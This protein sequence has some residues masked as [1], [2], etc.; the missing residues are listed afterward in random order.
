[1][2]AFAY[3]ALAP[4]GALSTGV[5]EAA[6]VA[7]LERRLAVR[8]LYPVALEQAADPASAAGGNARGTIAKPGPVGRGSCRIGGTS[9][10]TVDAVR[11]LATLVE[12]GFP[13]DRALATAARV[14]EGAVLADALASVRERVRAGETLATA[15]AAHPS[16]FPPLAV[17]MIRAGERGGHLAA[18]L[19]RLATT[20]ERER[21]LRARLAAAALYPVVLLV[22]G[23]AAVVLL[24]GVVLP[25]LAG[26]LT[27]S[28]AA[29]P[30][31]TRIVLLAGAVVT[32]WWPLLAGL[33]VA[34]GIAVT[35]TLG[36][37][38]GRDALDRFLYRA[39]G[40]GTLRRQRAAVRFGR[41]LAALLA[42]GAPAVTAID[43]A[44]DAVADAGARD[45][46]HA[47]RDAVRAGER[48]STAIARA[49]LFPPLF[50]QMVDVGESG[51]RL[52]EMLERGAAAMEGA[53]ERTLERLLRLSE[54]FLLVL[55]GGTVGFVA[56]SLLR[57]VYGVRVEGL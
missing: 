45:G 51:G 1:M 24:A 34:I 5:E 16:I 32:R 20:L 13:L 49:A 18:A 39:P 35:R 6:S 40:I 55:L 9:G 2:P 52:P 47:V 56:L 15:C 27:E 53:L 23:L 33:V 36:S 21:A 38:A 41:S 29:I 25:R 8:G 31:S 26:M 19:G 37:P 48:M 28:G 44:T 12:A 10:A 42:S 43:A 14:A 22:V 3:R 50:V 17:G 46:L 7:A 54:P 30:T 11:Y 4:D 57:A